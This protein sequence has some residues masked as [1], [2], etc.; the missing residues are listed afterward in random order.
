[1]KR[2]SPAAEARKVAAFNAA[3]PVGARVRYWTA[4]RGGE[5]SGEGVTLAPA[6]LWSGSYGAV[7]V[8][9]ADGRSDVIALT[10]VEALP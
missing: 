2:P 7:R 4:Q 5:P 1:M 9:R 6:E 8:R 3:H 10:H